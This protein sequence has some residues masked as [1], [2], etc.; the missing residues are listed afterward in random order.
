MPR[1][2]VLGSGF[3]HM[4]IGSIYGRYLERER[5]CAGITLSSDISL[6]ESEGVSEETYV[7]NCRGNILLNFD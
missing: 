4:I 3:T 5:G 6:D 2:N 7:Y 1:T